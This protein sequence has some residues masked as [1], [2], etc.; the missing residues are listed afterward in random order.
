MG[1]R[2]QSRSG[3]GV[4]RSV[5]PARFAA[6]PLERR[7][8][9]SVSAA[10]IA[11]P[12][13]V[14]GTHW[15]Y[16]GTDA[17]GD[18]NTLIE[19]AAGPTT[20][21]GNAC[22]Q[23]DVGPTAASHIYEGFDGAGNLLDYGGFIQYPS[24]KKQID[25]YTPATSIPAQLEAGT[26]YTSTYTDNE[27]DVDSTGTTTSSE[28]DTDTTMLV[29]D[30]TS[31]ITVPAG[32][33]DAYEVKSSDTTVTANG[34]GTNTTNT[35]TTDEWVV[36][37]VGYVKSIEYGT[38]GTVE[39]TFGL[40]VFK[41]VNSKLAFIQSPLNAAV[42]ATIKPPVVVQ[43]QDAAGNPQT[44]ATGSV[45][46]SLNGGSTTAKLGGTLTEPVSGGVATFSDL[47]VDTAG[48][49]YT[50]TATDSGSTPARPA[51][52]QGFD[53]TDGKLVFIQPPHD[54]TAGVKLN[55]GVIVELQDAQNNVIT[56]EDG[57]VV[58]LA[59]INVTGNA[60][61]TGNTA[62][63]SG[64]RATFP[65]LTFAKPGFYT[66]QASDPGGDAQAVSAKFKIAGDQLQFVKQ[67]ANTDPGKPIAL[68]VKLLDSQGKLVTDDTSSIA[69][70]LNAITGGA[71]ATLGGTML[72]PFVHGIATFTAKA[73]PTVNAP[74]TYTLTATE[75]D[76][77][78]G[79]LAPTNT[80]SAVDSAKFGVGG[81]HL[82]VA[83]QPG[84]ADVNG[85][86]PLSV[87]AVNSKGKLAT[88]ENGQV[89]LSLNAVTGG[90]GATLGGTITATITNGIATFPATAAPKING[91]GT[92]TLTAT[93]TGPANPAT[94]VDTKPFKVIGYTLKLLNTDRKPFAAG[95]PDLETSPGDF[96]SVENQ[97]FGLFDRKGHPVTSID[98]LGNATLSATAVSGSGSLV[99]ASSQGP[100][101]P[102][103]TFTTAD[104]N[105]ASHDPASG[106]T[107]QANY[108]AQFTFSSIGT[109]KVTVSPASSDA[110]GSTPASFAPFTYVC[111]V[112]NP[113][114]QDNSHGTTSSGSQSELTQFPV[115]VGIV[116]Q[117]NGSLSDSD[118]NL[119]VNQSVGFALTL[120]SSSSG[121]TFAGSTTAPAESQGAQ[122][123]SG[124][125]YYYTAAQIP[126]SF[127]RAGIYVLTATELMT[128]G[129]LP[130]DAKNAAPVPTTAPT[131]VTYRVNPDRVDVSQQPPTK[132][133]AGQPFTFAV[134][135]KDSGGHI[136]TDQ[137]ATSTDSL[138]AE[139][140]AVS[141]R[142]GSS[143]DPLATLVPPV[144][145]VNGVAT[146]SGLTLTPGLYR[147]NVTVI[148]NSL[149]AV[150]GSYVRGLTDLS[151]RSNI[152]L[153]NPF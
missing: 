148:D 96:S 70:S 138:Q 89:Q 5:N 109:Y 75:E 125:G 134:T 30:T 52:S 66:L 80:T 151:T 9:L 114:L 77:S 82:V 86:I 62:T 144:T 27:T 25:T 116:R 51:T 118:E 94:P 20:F 1:K 12:F 34:D 97:V 8:L 119:H 83:K 153:V 69:L 49:G 6:E 37:D 61:L 10:S 48:T 93:E 143:A 33:Y 103:S 147:L 35:T 152:F 126:I 45:T 87:K 150:S 123:A 135:L 72:A 137:N 43:L 29:S 54:G 110:S 113:S 115:V 64:G 24:G 122:D 21:N 17:A 38:D 81:L 22:Y 91:V 36:P 68:S 63:L 121:G 117:A 139:V 26:T 108:E 141:A 105:G 99:G 79:T 13:D 84:T 71:G 92:F 39:A 146:F 47:S 145:F 65:A 88:T 85:P 31:P 14:T 44:G 104:L 7:T 67:P 133:V 28:T 4:A 11:G 15:E 95:N 57:A 76:S 78:T 16:A 23:V 111:N 58:T 53:V 32:T 74:G 107:S 106:A 129:G 18:T 56:N 120:K 46:L 73:G 124:A 60:P 127:D 102:A 19:T 130:F 112:V 131:T 42:G 2:R 136:L 55:P 3:N 140:T 59:T 40:S 98:G 128:P 50:L 41:N 132:V 142:G 101:R 90:T 100:T 149:D